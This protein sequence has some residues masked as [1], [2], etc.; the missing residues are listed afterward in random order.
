MGWDN[1]KLRIFEELAQKSAE[2]LV[3]ILEIYG[4]LENLQNVPGKEKNLILNFKGVN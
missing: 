1:W 2:P 4:V 3:F